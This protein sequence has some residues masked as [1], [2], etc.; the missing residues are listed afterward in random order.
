MG[1]GFGDIYLGLD[2]GP[3]Y[4]AESRAMNEAIGNLGFDAVFTQARASA[5]RRIDAIVAAAR[6]D[7][8]DFGDARFE[9]LFDARELMDDVLADLCEAWFGVNDGPPGEALLQR[10]GVDWAW[11]EGR[12]MRYP[13]HFTALS[14]HL[15]QPHPGDVPNQLGP[16]YGQALRVAM[17]RF[18]QWHIE[19]GTVPRAPG[20]AGPAPLAQA[21]FAYLGP[22]GRDAD[23]VARLIIGVLMGRSR[24]PSA[25][26]STCCCSGAARPASRPCARRCEGAA[27]R[28]RPRTCCCRR[29]ARPCRCARCRSSTG[30]RWPRSISSKA[31]TAARWRWRRAT[32]WSWPTCRARSSRWRYRRI[33]I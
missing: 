31:A 18:V 17:R 23:F 21:A 29:C 7:A 15:F 20:A 8:I 13:G 3:Q 6:E 25:R 19:H 11:S 27:M 24:R 9:A 14:R 1:Q 10:G 28:R 30:A 26:C 5:T 16:R 2:A 4:D 22:P 32:S 33:T 12:P